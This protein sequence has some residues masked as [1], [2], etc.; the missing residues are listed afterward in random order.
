[1]DLLVTSEASL[2]V[3]E[4]LDGEVKMV[5]ITKVKAKNLLDCLKATK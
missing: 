1:M 4:T 3:F 5:G 2:D